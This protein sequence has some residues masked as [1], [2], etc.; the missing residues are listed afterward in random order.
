MA[1]N[2]N[3]IRLNGAA[4]T[5]ILAKLM[6]RVGYSSYVAQG[7]DY[8]SFFTKMLP[9]YDPDHCIGIHVNMIISPTP[10][11]APFQ[12]VLASLLG[13]GTIFTENEHQRMLPFSEYVAETLRETG[14]MHL[15]ATRPY[16]LGH[17]LTDSPVG[18]AA[19][20]IEKF[21]DWSDNNGDIYSTFTND[22]LL[23]NI[24]IYWSNNTITSSINYYYEIISDVKLMMLLSR[25]EIVAPTALAFFKKEI[26]ACNSP[27]Y[28]NSFKNII[29][30][31]E[32]EKGGHFA[33]MEQPEIF[34]KDVISFGEKLIQK[35]EIK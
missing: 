33:A 17:S 23:T 31:N 18:L 15:Q 2:N 25:E 29:Q 34:A 12:L 13:P 8:G 26:R 19:Y 4:I 27:W 5:V 20:I 6:K 30:K 24:M 3:M 32:F 9:V 22:Q 21:Y 35:K 7:G 28:S 16:S 11:Y 14:Y 10:W 1:N